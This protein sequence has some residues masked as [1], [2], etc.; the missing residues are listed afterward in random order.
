[1]FNVFAHRL[2]FCAHIFCFLLLATKTGFA[3][4]SKIDSLQIQLRQAKTDTGKLHILQQLNDA[5]TSVDAA[6]KFSYANQCR[7][8][9][10]KLHND[11]AVA[12]AYISMGISH[13]I[14]GKLDSALNYFS[15]AYNLSQKINYAA[16]MGKS[17]SD[18]GFA[19]DRLDNKKEA[20]KYYMQSL[21]ILKTINNKR[22]INQC[23]TNIGSL[24]FDLKQYKI[25]ET[26]FAQCLATATESK[27]EAGIGYA[28]YTMGNCYQAMNE[29]E[30]AL[31]YL[32][33]SL[34]IRL[35]LGDVN[36]TGLVKRAL[37]IVYQHKKQ[38]K[39]AVTVL[40]DGLKDLRSLKDKYEESSILAIIADV[41]NDMHNYDAAIAAGQQSL[42]I[43]YQI[44]SKVVAIDALNKLAISNKGK[45]NIS[46]AFKYQSIYIRTQDS[47]LDEKAL[48]DVTLTEFSRLRSENAT[49][50]KNNQSIASTN[51]NY[52][53]RINQYGN[54]IIAIL[55]LLAT[56]T[57]LLVVLFRRNVEKHVTN[58]LLVQQK[59]EI[60]LINEELSTQM[61]LTASQNKE[62]EKLNEVKNK[63][64]SII[65]HDLRGPLSTL[66]SLFVAYRD[67]DIGKDELSILLPQ[68]ED[69]ILSTSA[70]LDNLLEW[71]KNQLDG[72]TVDPVN[73]NVSDKIAENIRLFATKIDQ[74]KLNII[75]LAIRPI[76]VYADANMIDLVL[77]NLLSN[78]IKFCKTGDRITLTTEIIG[79]TVIIGIKDTGPGISDADREKLFK[80]EHTVSAGSHGEKGNHLGLILC[81]DMISQNN[82][83]IWFESSEGTGTTFW[84]ELPCGVV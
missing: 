69:T 1:M 25:A 19:Y 28:S 29:D 35:K 75:N 39:K 7:I 81:K 65:S 78:S 48:K 6:K 21:Q 73:F 67:G 44:K 74:K 32:N 27:D 11:K 57:I 70:F 30:K 66:Q 79:K 41:Y 15:I 36:G 34:A 72:M 8:L 77:R 43:A 76:W 10:Q 64:F 71:S 33:R 83:K 55:V 51:T 84:I 54:T 23:I 9:A 42:G 61:A 3:Q 63:F 22:L 2:Y 4:S 31:D 82:G 58:K 38:Y 46:E 5:Y 13:G 53:T 68:L 12:D 40:E 60:A 14:R 80:L 26:Y 17:L 62:L 37:G 52:R 20:I 50:S 24:Y 45:N 16:G 18:I 56:V 49:L 59:E 47:L